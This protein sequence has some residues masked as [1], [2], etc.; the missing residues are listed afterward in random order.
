MK[1][2]LMFTTL[3]FLFVGCVTLD[4]LTFTEDCAVWTIAIPNT[5][6]PVVITTCAPTFA[7]AVQKVKDEYGPMVAFMGAVACKET[8]CPDIAKKV[9]SDLAKKKAANTGDSEVKDL[10]TN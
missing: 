6:E 3:M 5:A 10:L 8:T 9:M 2:I 4:D 1:K 7:G